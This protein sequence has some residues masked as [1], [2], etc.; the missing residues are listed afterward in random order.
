V[1]SSRAISGWAI[2]PARRRPQPRRRPPSS[3]PGQGLDHQL[4]WARM[5]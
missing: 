2:R 3:E 4:S 5:L 1:H